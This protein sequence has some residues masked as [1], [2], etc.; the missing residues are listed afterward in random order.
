MIREILRTIVRRGKAIE[1]NT[2]PLRKGLNATCPDLTVLRW[3]KERGG[4]QV[5][6]GSDSHGRD[7]VGTGF[8]VALG[9]LRT[10]GFVCVTRFCLRIPERVVLS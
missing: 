3:Y 9:M 6:V 2:S 1:I 7:Q 4:E 5:T 8:D 10:A